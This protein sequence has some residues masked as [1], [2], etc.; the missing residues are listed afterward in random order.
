M[1]RSV[2]ISLGSGDLN[3]G[4]PN[5]TARLWSSENS[6]P[7]Q[8]V[9]SL[10]AAPSLV[11]ICINW[12]LI[13]KNICGRQQLRSQLIEEDDELEIDEGGITNVSVVNLDTVSQKVQEQIN[14]WLQSCEFLNIERQLRS[15]LHPAEEIRVIIETNDSLV[16][17]LP[18]HRWDFFNDYPKAG[19]ALSQL[20]YKRREPSQLKLPKNKVRI[21]AVLGNSQGIDLERE[22]KF[23]N[24]LEGAEI[25]FLVNPSRQEF[26]TLLWQNPG[27]DILFFAGHSHTEGTTGRIY[28]N[29]NQKNNSL[30]IEQLEEALKAAIDNG[31]QLAIFNSCDGLGLASALEKL[32]IPT[33][34]VMRES[35]PNLVAQ[36]FFKYFLEAFAV[37]RHSLYLAV[38]QARRKLQGVE[39]DFPGASWL[40]VI[41]QNPAVEPPNWL[42]LGGLPPCPYRGLFAFQEEDAHLFFGREQFTQDLV[43]ASKRKPLVAVVG[44]SGSGK[45]SVVFAGLV[46]HLRQDS[47]V[48]W[49]IVSFRSGNNPIEAL[50]RA[51]ASTIGEALSVP[52]LQTENLN[53][54]INQK[55]INQKLNAR[56][57]IELELEIALRKDN[58]ALYKIIESF[59]QQNPKTRLVL[60]ADQF[61]ELY[62]LCPEEERQGILDLL[63]NAVK[64]APAFTLVLTLRADFYGHALSYRPFSDALQ[65][66]VLNLGPM[67][68]EELRAA[69]EQPATQMQVRLEN[70]LTNKL[71]NACNDQSGRLPLLE[72]ALTQL[73]SKQTNGWLTHGG[74]DEIGGVEEALAIHAEAVYAQLYE[75]D[76]TRAQRVFM[77]LVRL[78]EGIEATRRLAI[79]DEVSSENWDLVTRLA[80]ARLVVTNRNESSG[81][82]TVEIVHEAL[83]RS[84]GRLEQWIQVD[85]EFRHAQE[86]LRSLIRQWESSGKDEGALLRG[87]PLLDAEYWRQKRTDELSSGEKHFIELSLALRDNEHKKQKRRRQLTISG[88]AGGLVVALSLA[89]LAWWNSQESARSEI[90]AISASSEA[91][92]T[93]HQDFD[94]LIESLKASKNL[95]RI[96]GHLAFYRFKEKADIQKQINI[97]LQEAV[98]KVR[99]RNSLERHQAEVIDVSFSPDGQMIATASADKTIK[100]WSR[101]GKEL[102]TLNGHGDKVYSVTFS[103]DGKTLATASWDTTVKLWTHEGQLITTLEGHKEAV[104]RVSFSPDGKTLATASDD[105][106]VKLWTSEGQLITTL[107]GHKAAVFSVSFSPDGKTLATA[108][109]DKTVKLWSKDGKE[110]RT[111][112]GHND[113]VWSVSFSPDGKTIATASQDKTV[114]LWSI[115]G[116]ELKILRGHKDAV[117]RVTFSPDGKTIATASA[118]KTA[119]LWSSDGEKL[120]TLTGHKNW[121]WDVSFS[122]DGQMMATASKDKT[123]KLWKVKG[124]ELQ[125]LQAHKDAIYSVSFS[126]D[127]R[128]IATASADKTVKLWSWDGQELEIFKGYDKDVTDVSFSSDGKTIATATT[129]G[130]VK[131]WTREGKEIKTFKAHKDWIWKVSFSPDGKSFATASTDKTVKLWNL[132]G[133]EIHTLKGHEDTVNS[134]SFSPD[135]KTIAT[136][137]W[138]KTVKLWTSEGKLIT[139]FIGHTDG[140]HNVIFSPNGR[141]IASASEDKT[142]KLW[143]SEGKLITT[144]T[145]HDGGV[146]RVRFS[147]EGHTLATAS[148]D[149]TVKLWNLDG[150]ELR[151]YKGHEEQVMSVNFSPDGHLLASSDKVGRLIVWNLNFK[152]DDLLR[153]GC[154]WVCDYLKTNPHVNE[155]DRHICDGIGI[156][157]HEMALF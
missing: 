2:V 141:I 12:Q 112:T 45:S 122:P 11:E 84:W 133:K 65:G 57:L 64:L 67:S 7:Q 107:K 9:G 62:T 100:L 96:P 60:I 92:L 29:E 30:T 63:L 37:E 153:Y 146:F 102:Q 138:D 41:C 139:T 134:V 97:L 50:V 103:P 24:S 46:S 42:N 91:L 75:A 120:Q 14:H 16:R 137:S 58:K 151:T 121:V 76:R 117:T 20:E 106:T 83:I 38:Q 129:D 140:V 34:I 19:M 33:V 124:K 148:L 28:I 1:S 69:I 5:V 32:N 40:P 86:Q 130:I 88:L 115:E 128:T 79:R 98:Y 43:A 48:E 61:E 156:E 53:K 13:Y 27:W 143:T 25:V 95:N 23:L 85:G 74:Y 80:D 78:G 52:S 82:E 71:I 17:R 3:N 132:D 81:E 149:N 157:H 55:D 10:P 126:P 135:G 111:L 72:F 144:L 90:K 94:A 113:W 152:P 22:I 6:L 54:D 155:S 154:N 70:E 119:I 47:N 36:E 35:V 131:L 109:A 108:S 89:G 142:V 116:K 51:F 104:N 31:L 21:L 145:G 44:P 77:Q 93:S 87:K 56:R 73:W 39:D 59:V 125:I 127:G 118:D 105:K 150:K 123:V 49:Q 26:N 136:A 99:E 8:F 114:K 147:P 110:L 4:F 66:A 18:W 68:H 101:D 15:Q